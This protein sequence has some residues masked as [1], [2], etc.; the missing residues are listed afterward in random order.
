MA[1]VKSRWLQIMV[2]GIILWGMADVTLR[3]TKNVLYFPTIMVIGAFLVPLAF[4]AYFFQ[5]ENVLDRGIHTRSILSTL[6]MCGLLGGLIGTF[7]AGI[8]E[9]RTI[10]NT[11]LL[12]LVWVG[13]IEEFAKLIVPVAVYITMRK[14]F[15]SEMDGLLFGVAAGM[16]F[17]ALETMGYELISLITSFGNI[18]VLDETIL[19]RGLLSPAGHA[20]WTGL[21]T[22]TLWRERE[23]T[24]QSLTFIVVIFFIISA[25]LHSAWDYAGTSNSAAVVIPSYI[26]IAG[27]SLT[28]LF[29]RFREAHKTIK[30]TSEPA[31]AATVING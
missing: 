9:S 22:A 30:K 18:N 19:V 26:A 4:V 29:L 16:M 31:V 2:I 7:A 12:S 14:R 25:A 20:A 15:S 17:A 8:L 21:I 1:L 24:G 5:Q 23:R 13:P 11:S 6:V 28:L 10:S 3:L 27:V